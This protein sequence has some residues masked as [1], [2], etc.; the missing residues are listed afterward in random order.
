MGRVVGV[1]GGKWK[2]SVECYREVDPI[3][4]VLGSKIVWGA[5]RVKA[6]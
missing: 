6:I 2:M 4:K 1:E 3:S 5:G